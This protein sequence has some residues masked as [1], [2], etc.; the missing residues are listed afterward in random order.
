MDEFRSRLASH[1]KLADRMAFSRETLER[2]RTA[3][4]GY[5]TCSRPELCVYAAGSLGRLE[6]G[7]ISDLDVFLFADR[8]DR[9]QGKRSLTRLEEIMALAELVQ[10]N[11]E[12]KLPAFS[13]DG[14]FFKV[15]EVTDLVAGTGTAN[16]DSE[17]LFT[18]RLL[19]LLESKCIAND[20]L[21]SSATEQI[22]QMYFRDGKGR[23]DYRPLFLLN[24]ILRYWRTLCLNYER[25]RL[26]PHKPWW[27]KNLNL[28]FSRK[29][30]VFSTVLAILADQIDTFEKFAVISSMTP[31]ERLAYAMDRLG[32]TTLLPEFTKFLDNYEEFLAAKSHAELEVLEPGMAAHYRQSAQEFDDFIHAAFASSRLDRQLVRYLLI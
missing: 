1:E 2:V 9:E 17:N 28:K 7:Q 29:L 11:A 23:S 32:E 30:T 19:L 6:T 20:T 14:E 24:D 22:V 26:D 27:K 15:H 21:Y 13:G 5:T 31:M 12:L 4:A 18:T 16:D 8:T 10:I 25:T 3:A